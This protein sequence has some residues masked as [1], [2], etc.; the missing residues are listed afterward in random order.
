[1]IDGECI[2]VDEEGRHCKI[3]WACPTGSKCSKQTNFEGNARQVKTKTIVN[4]FEKLPI[5]TN[6]DGKGSNKGSSLKRKCKA[7]QTE[8]PGPTNHKFKPSPAPR[9]QLKW[10]EFNYKPMD[11][12]FKPRPTESDRSPADSVQSQG[13]Q[14]GKA[15]L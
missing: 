13:N 5:R 12:Y 6:S 10:P 9:K 14:A 3:A 8:G 11:H 2:K 4:Y 15:E 1:M 7:N